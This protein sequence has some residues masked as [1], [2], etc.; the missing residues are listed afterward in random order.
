[1]IF[2][3]SSR[4]L[5]RQCNKTEGQI[6]LNGYPSIKVK[7]N[8]QQPL[9]CIHPIFFALFKWTFLSSL[10]KE[11]LNILVFNTQ[12]DKEKINWLYSTTLYLMKGRGA[13][14]CLFSGQRAALWGSQLR[15]NGFLFFSPRLPNK[16][17]ETSLSTVCLFSTFIASVFTSLHLPLSVTHTVTSFLLPVRSPCTPPPP[18]GMKCSC[19]MVFCL[20][21]AKAIR[22]VLGWPSTVPAPPL[23]WGSQPPC[24][25]IPGTAA[26][27]R[28]WS[29][30]DVGWEFIL[31]MW[32]RSMDGVTQM[33]CW[34]WAF[35][36]WLSR[37][38]VGTIPLPGPL[39]PPP[40][41][42]PIAIKRSSIRS[43]DTR[44]LSWD[45]EPET[46]LSPS[47]IK[48]CWWNILGHPDNNLIFGI[49]GNKSILPWSN[50]Q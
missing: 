42:R 25:P 49:E 19:S 28:S 6:W 14:C 31:I 5:K 15:P 12:S 20:L 13:F 10:Y 38:M 29:W 18:P 44:S 43:G 7:A 3:Q 39:S 16:S 50:F 46:C 21:L 45:L 11:W 2:C 37:P 30:P 27:L 1:M 34:D 8:T 48:L 26:E 36:W 41:I 47:D 33:F 24:M 4:G 22:R 9:H 40:I 35:W 17:L 23:P 32:C